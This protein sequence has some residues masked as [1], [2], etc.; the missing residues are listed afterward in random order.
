MNKEIDCIHRVV[1]KIPKRM[2]RVE[3]T[4]SILGEKARNYRPFPNRKVSRIM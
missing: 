4:S 1:I 2:L 3:G